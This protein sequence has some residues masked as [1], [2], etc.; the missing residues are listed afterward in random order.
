MREVAERLRDKATLRMVAV[1]GGVVEFDLVPARSAA[2]TVS[3]AVD[4]VDPDSEMWITVVGDG[5]TG[6]LSW[7]LEVVE[8]AIT[9]NIAILEGRGRRRVEIEVAPGDVRSSTSYGRGFVPLP[10][11]RAAQVTRFAPY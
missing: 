7:L 1:G 4:P 8:A 5:E 10:W 11:R 6:D 9:G 3:V 2:A